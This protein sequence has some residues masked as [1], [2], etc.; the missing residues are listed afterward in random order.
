M[1][2]E[3][4]IDENHW[5]SMQEIHKQRLAPFIRSVYLLR[6]M[7]D[8]KYLKATVYGTNVGKRYLVKGKNLIE[9]IAKWEDGT[10]H[11]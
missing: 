9:F 3:K 2:E 1:A 8:K 11:K 7:A 4:F 10:F 5:Y 6:T